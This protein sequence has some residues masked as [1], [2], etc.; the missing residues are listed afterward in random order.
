MTNEEFQLARFA[1]SPE[2]AGTRDEER[3]RHGAVKYA[4]KRGMDIGAVILLLPLALIALVAAALIILI[5]RQ[6]PLFFDTCVR[7]GGHGTFAQVKLRTMLSDPQVLTRYLAAHPE[8]VEVY[9]RSRN[10]RHDP[11]KTRLGLLLRKFSVDEVP[12]LWNVLCGHMSLV[13]P[14]P[15]HTEQYDAR[16]PYAPIVASVRPGLTGLAQVSGRKNLSLE[17]REELDIYYACNWTLWLDLKILF[18]T[19][20]AILSADGAA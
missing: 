16:L 19:P 11:R 7:R 6:R 9:L 17:R 20:V 12:Q 18:R 8:E 1:L 13:G 3:Q 15:M 5:D 10:L 4:V 14:R 2:S